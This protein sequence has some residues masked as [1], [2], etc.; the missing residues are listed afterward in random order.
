[1]IIQ[2][3]ISSISQKIN[4]LEQLLDIKNIKKSLE[5]DQ[6]KM[7]TPNF[8][9]DKIKYKKFVKNFQTLKI[10]I[11]DFT[12]LKNAMEELECMY[13][14]YKEEH[15]DTNI[16]V[17]L[18]KT[19]KLV[20][21]IE[22]KTLF[23]KEDTYNAILQISSGA[24]GTESCDWTAM[25][26]RMY[27]LWGEHNQ[28]IVNKIHHTPG[29]IIGTKTVTLE[30]NGIYAFGYLKGENGVHRLIRI[31]PFN[32]NSKRHTTFSSVFVYP[33]IEKKIDININVS[34]IHWDTFR[35]RG[36]GGQNV[37]KVETGVRLKHVPTGIIIENT[38]SR[39]QIQNRQTA[40]QILK[41]RLFEIEIKK[42]LD[43]KNKIE[44]K[45][46][47]IEW[48]SQIRNYIMH[49]YQLVKDLRTGYE[50]HK[51]QSVMNG[52]INTFLKK[53]LIQNNKNIF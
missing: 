15:I 25:L 16:K 49:P 17:Q 39:S 14:I 44:S 20:D 27:I 13:Y 47:K 31:S 42:N 48:G 33:F 4:K 9:K 5:H 23:K 41:S 34:D 51:V 1:M 12:Q 40:L 32:N 26:M 24:G 11:K 21:D 22:I 30:I 28:F 2:D 37:N 7:L 35:S 18:N 10:K 50:T 38:E 36:S 52:E 3:E 46:K 6:D 8:W 45:K 29:D 43:K 53:F 19:K